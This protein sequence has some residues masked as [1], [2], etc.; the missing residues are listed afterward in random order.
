ML[1]VIC[2]GSASKDIFLPTD[3]GIIIDTPEDLTSQKKISFELGAKYQIEDRYE[4]PGGVAANVSQGLARLGVKVGCCSKIGDDKLGMWIVDELEKENVDASLIQ[5]ENNCKSDLSAIIVDTNSGDHT[6]FFNRD[7]NERLEIIPEKIKNTKWFFI[8]AL[9][10]S[11]KKSWEENIEDIIKISKNENIRIAFNPG[12]RNIKDNSEKIARA[13][14]NSEVLILNKDEAI[15]IV[16]GYKKQITGD[17]E[18]NDEKFLIKELQNL[19]PKVVSL[20]DGIRGAW[21]CDENNLYY[22]KASGNNPIETT[23]AGDGFSSGFLAAYIQGKSVKEALK[24]GTANGGS[25]VEFYGAK[26]GLIKEN[27]MLEK[28]EKIKIETL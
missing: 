28:I 8:S 9:N 23:G 24:W 21:A 3:K 17:K 4:A 20:T 7:A 6:I 10:G 11:I 5:I 2:I 27:E 15:E 12:Q 26:D 25:V 16:S 18:F 22:A 13:I 19:G 1:K 14:E